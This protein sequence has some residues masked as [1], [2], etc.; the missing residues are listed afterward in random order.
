LQGRAVEGG[1]GETAIV[2]MLRDEAP[3]FMRLALDIGF[4]GLPLGVE[5]VEFKIEIMLGRFAGIDRAALGFWNKQASW[6]ALP[7]T[8]GRDLVQRQPDATWPTE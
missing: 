3:A 7:I 5:R 4:A 2:I 8:D 6:S 1:A